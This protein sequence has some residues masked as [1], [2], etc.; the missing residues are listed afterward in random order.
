[1]AEIYLRDQVVASQVATLIVQI[2]FYTIKKKLRYYQK[3]YHSQPQH[4]WKTSWWLASKLVDL[5][6]LNKVSNTGIE[7]NSIT[8]TKRIPEQCQKILTNFLPTPDVLPIPRF[9]EYQYQYLDMESYLYQYLHFVPITEDTI[10]D[11]HT[12]I[13]LKLV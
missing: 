1:M 13:L 11:T 8:I 12:R 2:A 9:D 4:F 3:K 7:F 5:V 6:W 10:P